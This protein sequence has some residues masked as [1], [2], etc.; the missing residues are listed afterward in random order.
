MGSRLQMALIFSYHLQLCGLSNLGAGG[1]SVGGHGY[2]WPSD[3]PTN[4]SR[5]GCP[6]LV[7]DGRQLGFMTT[8]ALQV[9]LLPIVVPIT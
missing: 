5:V 7:L 1:V 4:Y 2:K 8:N 6:S 9:F 3:L